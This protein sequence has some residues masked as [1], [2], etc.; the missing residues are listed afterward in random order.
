MIGADFEKIQFEMFGL[1]L[2]EPMGFITDCIIG[3]LAFVFAFIVAR[4]KSVHPF[5]QYWMWFFIF[6][7]FSS[8]GGGFAHLFYNYWGIPGKIAPWTLAVFSVYCGEQGMISVYP[9]DKTLSRLKIIS[10]WKAIFVMVAFILVL[11]LVDLSEKP[12]LAFL[13]VALNTI[14]GLFLA[15]GVLGYI[16]YKKGLSPLYKYF[17][18][19]VLIML[20]S[21]FVFLLKINLHPWFDKND[22]SHVLIALG[23]TFYFV[24]VKSIYKN[25]LHQDMPIFKT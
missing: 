23:A 16:Y 7:G 2:M 12:E 11:T 5:Y 17:Y 18:F 10:F 24:G 21:S 3:I 22:L 8:T 1:Q 13:P 4:Y 14:I 6:L 20:P 15:T 25:G 19:A 9:N